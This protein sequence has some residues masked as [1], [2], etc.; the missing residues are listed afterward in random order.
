[1][2]ERHPMHI[3]LRSMKL[4]TTY[5]HSLSTAE[6]ISAYRWAGIFSSWS[7]DNDVLG[8]YYITREQAIAASAYWR[9]VGDALGK[10]EQ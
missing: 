3:R 2:N 10:S 4:P 5:Q 1:M 7:K 8:F 6:R 9:S